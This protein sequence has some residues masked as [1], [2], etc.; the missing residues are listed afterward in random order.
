MPVIGMMP[1]VIPT[2]TMMCVNQAMT[3]ALRTGAGERPVTLSWLPW[4][5]TMG[6]NALFNRN[7]RLGGTLY[8]AGDVKITNPSG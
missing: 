4:N 1:I 6:G 5:H 7:M 8:L 3:A 2:F